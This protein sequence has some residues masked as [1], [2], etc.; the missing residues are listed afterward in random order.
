L[1]TGPGY[2]SL[3]DVITDTY[4]K[5]RPKFPYS[6]SALMFH[7]FF[8]ADFRYLDDPKNEQHDWADC[9]HQVHLGDNWVFNTGGEVRYRAVREVN[10]RLT[11]VTNNFEL[12]RTRPYIDLWY[13]D[14]FRVYVE[15]LYADSA[16]QNLPPLPTDVTAPTLQ[17]A[18]VDMKLFCVDDNNAYLRIGRQE[19][20][21][22]S[23]R[24]ISPLDWAN[25]RRT[26][27]GVRALYSSEKWNLDAFW[28]Q[29]VIP[30][31]RNFSSVDDKQNFFGAW[32]TY[33]P[34]KD[35]A[36]DAYYLFL[37]NAN[38]VVQGGIIR[39]PVNVHTI[40]GRW[41]GDKN[42]W[43]WDVEGAVQLGERGD[44]EVTA[45]MATV[46]GGYNFCKLPWNP[47]F[48]VYYDYAS[49]DN[50]PNK[51]GTFSTFNQLFPFGHYYL[52]SMD[53]VG[54]QNIH[55]INC[56]LWL[57]PT[58]WITI[59]SMYHH[60]ELDQAKD[61]LYNSAG[62]VERRDPTGRAGTDVGDEIHFLANF[63]LSNHS[64]VLVGYAH[65]FSGPFIK[66]TGPGQ[67][68]EL[69]YVQYCFRW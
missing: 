19:L 55:D 44:Q 31:A 64:D 30:D 11:G 39:A 50:D 29:P 23:E 49:G 18:F 56:H 62:N 65:L 38:K 14:T 7:S 1:P 25:T 17:N 69:Y 57:Y 20:L 58:K 22:G 68:S 48:W 21:F 13:R 46:G 27:Q 53:L 37:D 26:F 66:Q 34:N 35:Q 61:A 67:D 12:F 59:W 6:A 63:H 43:L 24:L 4:R 2:Y 32:A 41:S 51:G 10:S 47:T 3:Y 33:K 5:D 36:I 9:L 60:F 28:V 40:G 8:D 54:R 42:N 45:G 15:F 52:G 16:D